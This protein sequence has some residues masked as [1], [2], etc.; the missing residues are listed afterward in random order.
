MS[1]GELTMKVLLSLLLV[2]ILASSLANVEVKLKRKH[3]RKKTWWAKHITDDVY[4]AGRLTETELKYVTEDGFKSIISMFNFSRHAY[5]GDERIPTSHETARI[6]RKLT[7]GVEFRIL[8]SHG[9][10]WKRLFTVER[11][12]ELY[13]ELPK[14]ILFTGGVGYAT[15]FTTLLYFLQ[16][17][18]Y[19]NLDENEKPIEVNTGGLYHKGSI[20]GYDYLLSPYL[21]RLVKNV[22]DNATL[23]LEKPDT[24]LPEWDG[25]YWHMKPVYKNWFIAGQIQ[26]NH[27]ERIWKSGITSIINVREGEVAIYDEN[28]NV[29]DVTQEEVT[30]LNVKDN[31]GE[32]R[33]TRENLRKNRIKL[34]KPRAFISKTSRTNYQSE[35]PLRFGDEIG[36]NETLERKA[37][38]E[39]PFNYYHTPIRTYS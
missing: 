32:D 22:T 36:Y 19:K 27:L 4:T 10:H 24:V 34:T 5:R 21:K 30:L 26:C 3:T 38:E 20:M 29:T 33:Q 15:T 18:Y 12:A 35:N 23:I 8:L 16:R 9:F 14:P 17:N 11:F 2:P 1:E 13:Q 31:T 6:V 25:K 28:G 37:I 39:L 7:R